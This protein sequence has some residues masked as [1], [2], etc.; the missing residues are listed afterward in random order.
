MSILYFP[1][2][3]MNPAEAI[4]IIRTEVARLLLC[5]KGMTKMEDDERYESVFFAVWIGMSSATKG[6]IRG[7]MQ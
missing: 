2:N 7:S 1:V 6:S 3:D 4:S 5:V